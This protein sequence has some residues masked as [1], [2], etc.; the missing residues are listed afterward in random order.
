[1]IALADTSFV[2]AVGN[3][4]DQYHQICLEIYSQQKTIHIPQ[5]TFAEVGYMLT[6]QIGNVGLSK[7]LLNIPATK[8]H[9]SALEFE[10]IYRTAELLKQ[11][12]DSRIDFVDATIAAVAER[13]NITRV[14]TLDQRVFCIFR[15][16]H[17]EYFE[18]L[19]E[20]L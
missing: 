1:M 15:P 19:P 5:S 6:R 4:T 13:L 8:F 10:D 17:C 20:S 2:V 11:Y 3:S 7:F 18:L 14:L 12:A 9:L 16:C